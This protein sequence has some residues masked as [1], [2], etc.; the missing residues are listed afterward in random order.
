MEFVE[1]GS[2]IIYQAVVFLRRVFI[3]YSLADESV[4]VSIL[5]H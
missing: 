1:L 2:Y 3:K 4:S 5:F